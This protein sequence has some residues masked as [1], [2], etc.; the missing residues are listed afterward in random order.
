MPHFSALT[1]KVLAGGLT[2]QLARRVRNPE[3]KRQVTAVEVMK[4]RYSASIKRKHEELKSVE[5]PKISK[6]IAQKWLELTDSK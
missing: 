4:L 2:D 1:G 3:S 5:L 6:K